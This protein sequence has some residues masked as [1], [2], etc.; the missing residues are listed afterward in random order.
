MGEYPE[1]F[2]QHRLE[3]RDN[4]LDNE[5]NPY[6]YYFTATH[7]ID[8]IIDSFDSLEAKGVSVSCAG[9]ILSVRKM[10]KS[11]FIDLIDK[12]NQFQLYV[13]NKES[14][15][16]A[17]KL[18]P[19]IDIGDWAGVTGTLFKTHT[20]QPTILAKEL[21]MLGKSVADVPF[22][23]IH[24]GTTSYTLSNIEVRRQQRYLDWIT[25]PE[26]V[27]RFEL[28]SR[29]IS[30]IRRHMESE[31]FI[32]VDTPTLEMVYGGA[33]AR[34]FKTDVW[35]LSGQKVYL[36]VSLE[37]PL[38]RYIIGGFPKVFALG[39]C[40]RNEGI[41]AT[42]NPEFTLLEWYEAYTDYEDQMRRF[43][44]LTCHIV[45]ECTGSLVI[46]FQGKKIDF[47]PPWKRIRIPDVIKE[48]FGCELGA[49]D[50][51][52]LELRLD[53]EMSGE[54]LSF[55]G[56]TREQYRKE[57][58][59]E[60]L[61]A[62]VMKV[63]EEEL[64]TSGRLWDPCFIC[65]HP[66]DISPLTKVKRGNPLFVE[67]FE[68]HIATFEMGN[69]YSELTDPVEQY[70]RFA[71]QRSTT[72]GKDYDDHPVDMDFIHAIACGMP[73]TGGVGYGIDR[74]VMLLAGKESIRDVI[75]FPMRTSK[76]PKE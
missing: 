53:G 19:N 46:E 16:N 39:K 62:L 48:I 22:G 54:K 76:E 17:V 5:V 38:K 1:F 14:S 24:D 11:W 55:V 28:R 74:L 21:V 41:D 52:E 7:T 73:P 65:D 13:H 12:G 9:R 37:L 45:K 58:A 43:E 59:E 6:P 34:P 25:D 72:T 31:G 68:P 50:R 32:E 66:R 56:I 26:S 57:L 42:H 60:K 70:E 36:N 20:G 18:V 47:T 69:A 64:E 8:G 61:G 4:L 49:I 29:I 10:G 35:A 15:E 27:K 30:L 3:K 63:I 51:K 33:E 71:E 2:Q 67:R 44:N 23:K 40:F 75:P